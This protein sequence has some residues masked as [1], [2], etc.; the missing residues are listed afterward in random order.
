MTISAMSPMLEKAG[1]E[2]A[3]S[4]KAGKRIVF[5]GSPDFAIPAL[6]RLHKSN[7]IIAVYSQPP[8][9]AGRGMREKLVP[10]AQRATD[11]GLPTY[12]PK[13]LR[14]TGA[15]TELASLEADLFVVVAF[16]LL[17]PKAVLAMPRYG[18]INGHA[19][20]LPRW[21]GAAPIQRAIAAGDQI[22]GMAAM[23]ME[24]GL[25]TGPVI[26]S[27]PCAIMPDD[28]AGSL[29][30]KLSQ[31]NADLL[32]RVVTGLPDNL[33]AAQ[34][35]DATQSLYAP[36][37]SNAECAIDWHSTLAQIDRQIRAF[38]PSP[39]TYF[40]GPKGRIKIKAAQPSPDQSSPDQRKNNPVGSFMGLDE[41]G[42]MQIAASDGVLKISQLQ[43]AGSKA[44]PAR[45]FLNGQ[46]LAIGHI[47]PSPTDSNQTPNPDPSQP[48]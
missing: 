8:R 43:P 9:P 22:T 10:L 26:D 45:D 27:I 47:F 20:L 2:K 1:S 25:D 34:Q 17:L 7:Q 18:C 30:D 6:E 16:G 42:R 13:S 31:M 46:P 38:S 23:L 14:D 11:L 48:S 32:A 5:M 40:T 21:R 36:K 15:Q 3:G 39:G 29:H 24:E 4:E 19:S 44:M 33:Q 35:Q 28:D 41:N 37:I 12:W